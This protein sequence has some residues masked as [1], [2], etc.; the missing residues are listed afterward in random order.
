LENE[1]NLRNFM[2]TLYFGLAVLFCIF[3]NSSVCAQVNSARNPIIFADVPDMSIV[4]VGD[5]YYMSSTTMHM[6]PGV[7]IMKS[8]DLV[9]W[10]IV[11]Y[12]YD[13]LDNVD[14]LTLNNGK[15]AYGKGTWASSIRYHKDTF[16]I[17]TFSQTTGKTYVYSTRDIEKGSWKVSSFS[18]SYH[19]NTLFFDDDGR[20]Y[21]IYGNIKLRIVELKADLSGPITGTDQVLIEDTS[22]P[23]GT[24]SGLGEG[25]QLFKIKGKYYL[26][27]ITWPRGGIRTVVVHRADKITGTW[28]GRLVLQDKGVAQGGLI[29]TPDGNWFAYLFRDYGAVGRIPYLVPVKW[30]DSWPVLGI[31]GKVPDT[32]DL[33]ASKGL[34]PGIIA[35]DEFNRRKG[36]RALPLVWQW[37]HNP[38]NK[39]W[40]V[41]ERKG[42]LRLSTNRIDTVFVAARNTLTQRTFGPE[43]SGSTSIDIS[44]M[45][46]GD[47]AGLALLQR[48]YGLVGV[49]FNNGTKSI[50]MIN[51]QSGN[52]VQVQSVPLIQTTVCLKA[53]CDFNER[54]D[55]AYFYYSLDGKSWSP[56]GSQLN[57]EYS[58]PHF[59]GYRYGLFNYSSKTPG[60]FVDFDYFHIGNQITE[61]HQKG[62]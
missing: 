38:D 14:A 39:L 11:S 20:I 43:C 45:K 34:I 62:Q 46:E 52:A 1:T 49:K 4:R 25:S 53:E 35:P 16:Y 8:K 18:P 42:F 41:T 54:A 56:I 10:Q 55:I 2:K 59:M 32:L 7:P 9:N 61:K 48:K 57:M 26:F 44:N 17:S 22:A 29:D 51:A 27:N 36:D 31:A 15:N 13:V 58:M 60:G 6:S 33:P 3:I 12:A 30:E 23:S 19:D 24:D 47:F 40:S 21:L 28:E 50:V 37:N 5:T